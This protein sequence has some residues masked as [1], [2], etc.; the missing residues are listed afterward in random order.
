MRASHRGSKSTKGWK[1]R[2]PHLTSER[3]AL[4][5]RCGTK[6]F[7]EPKQLK[8]PIVAKTG[9]CAI[10]CAGLEAALRRARQFHHRKAAAKAKRLGR[11]ASCHWAR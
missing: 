1:R 6:A 3:R 9:G 8:F 2:A 4:K 7:L 5:A 10:D 11:R